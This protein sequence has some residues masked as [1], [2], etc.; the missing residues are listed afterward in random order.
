MTERTAMKRIAVVDDKENILRVLRVI[1][2]KSGW[3]PVV[4]ERAADALASITASPPDLVISDI[5][6]EGMDG[7]ELFYELRSRGIGIPF[8]FMTAYGTI[9]DAVAL[10]KQGAV[11]YLT[12]PLDYAQLNRRIEYLLQRGRSA[13]EPGLSNDKV[14]IGSSPAMRAIFARIKLVAETSSTV[15]IEGESGTGKELAARAVHAASPRRSSPFVA[16]NCAAFSPNILE[17]EL[18]GHERGAFTDAVRLKKGVFENADTGTLFLDEVSELSPATQVALL[19]VMQ[20][21]VFTRVGGSVQIPTDVRIIAAANRELKGLVEAG[22]FRKDLF[23]R[24][25]VIPLRIP[26][27]RE[28]TEDIRELAE[29]F[30]GRISRREALPP[31]VLDEPFI[32]TLSSYS[33]PGNIREL[34]NV[35][36]R[37]IVLYRPQCLTR[38]HLANEPEFGFSGAEPA[39]A[40][41]ENDER[42]LVISALKSCGGNK[43]RTCELLGISRRAL[44]YKIERLRIEKAEYLSGE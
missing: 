18:F 16:V 19:R 41:P 5:R 9:P 6:M 34:E 8:I 15:L 7:R 42:A 2:Q 12:K 13:A 28:H 37:L 32:E 27:L 22:S 38:A 3:E 31:P 17:S 40:E 29:Y 11:D 33:W 20:E 36:E 44:Y 26:P 4:F 23:Y 24:L 10:M 1:L 35:I 39:A 25:H 14:M 43:S 30:A 21:K